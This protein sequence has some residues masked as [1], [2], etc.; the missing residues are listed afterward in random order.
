MKALR[1]LIPGTIRARLLLLV[2]GAVLAAQAATL[3]TVSVYQRNHAQTVAVDLIATTIRTLQTAMSG[4]APQDRAEFVQR[5]SL[6]QWRLWSRPLP[7]GA[8]MHRMPK[9]AGSPQSMQSKP[10]ASMPG[11]ASGQS[12]PNSQDEL[13]RSLRG[14][15]ANLNTRLGNDTR[16]AM[17]RGP[18]PELYLSLPTNE[19]DAL[20][21]E[22][23]V[24]PIDRIDPPFTTATI[25]WWSA[26]IALILLMAAGFSWHIARPITRLA[27]A[28]NLLAS[29]THERVTPSGPDETRRLGE[30]FNAMLDALEES[31]KVRRTLLAG[32]PHDLKGPLSRMWL[33]IEMS[34]DPTLKDGLRKDL[35]EMQQMVDQFIGFVRGTDPATY[36]FTRIEMGE[37]LHERVANWSAAEAQVQLVG[38]TDKIKIMM[39]PDAMSRLVDNLI[40][41]A[42]QHGAPPVLVSLFRHKDLALLSVSDH[43]TGIPPGQFQEA[44]RPFVRLDQA[45][46]KT[47]SVGLGLALVDAIAKAHGG[48]LTL[49][50]N[51]AGG[52]HAEV[53]LP[54]SADE[55]I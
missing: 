12:L 36:R 33:R 54:I 10:H 23:L 46:T 6:G 8:R 52:L 29:G 25:V 40:S 28:T 11:G 37:W 21:R 51:Q 26:G 39:D 9:G 1:W 47:G 50:E 41:N 16:V 27:Q 5:T 35:R 42:L 45:R 22:W 13:R 31:D 3:Y 48:K 20:P 2:L 24:I 44:L 4:I 17:S 30:S 34:D 19:P 43:G 53:S 15:V 49:S 38:P 7:A 32:L 18:H 14:L 55:V